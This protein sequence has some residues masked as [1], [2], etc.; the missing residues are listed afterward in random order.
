MDLFAQV[1]VVSRI[2]RI[3]S[4]FFRSDDEYGW[5]SCWS[6]DEH[7]WTSTM[8]DFD[9]LSDMSQPQPIYPI[10]HINHRADGSFFVPVPRWGHKTHFRA[11]GKGL[12]FSVILRNQP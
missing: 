12:L 6:D 2:L 9:N 3:S 11:G 7:G 8:Y 1:L 10:P 4:W 5:T